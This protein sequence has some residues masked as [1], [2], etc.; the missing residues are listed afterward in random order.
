MEHD[1]LQHLSSSSEINGSAQPEPA[2]GPSPHSLLSFSRANYR[3]HLCDEFVCNFQIKWIINKVRNIKIEQSR[4]YTSLRHTPVYIVDRV[5]VDLSSLLLLVAFILSMMRPS[6]VQRT[7][8][9]H[10]LWQ[11]FLTLTCRL[12]YQLTFSRAVVIYI[13]TSS[14]ASASLHKQI[15]FLDIRYRCPFSGRVDT[16]T[17]LLSGQVSTVALLGQPPYTFHLGIYYLLTRPLIQKNLE[18][19][20][21]HGVPQC[22]T[23]V[24]VH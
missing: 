12:I 23:T 22:A 10:Y 14:D 20:Q 6:L 4:F 15:D 18:T 3:D 24:V 7:C 16:Y 8:Q 2:R 19:V 13:H 11:H 21:A 17:V 1:A 9:T 5:D